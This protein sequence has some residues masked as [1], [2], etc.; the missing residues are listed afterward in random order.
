[1]LSGQPPHFVERVLCA[2]QHNET[3]YR[4][5]RRILRGFIHPVSLVQPKPCDGTQGDDGGHRDRDQLCSN[6]Q[7]RKPVHG[8]SFS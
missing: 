5:H 4:V 6:L 8:S 2:V 1:M 7:V 3:R